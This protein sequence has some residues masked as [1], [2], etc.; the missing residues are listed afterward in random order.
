MT[1]GKTPQTFHTAVYSELSG[2]TNKHKVIKKTTKSK[3]RICLQI[4]QTCAATLLSL[5]PTQQRAQEWHMASPP[6]HHRLFTSRET[7]AFPELNYRETLVMEDVNIR[8]CP[9]T[10]QTYNH[11]AKTPYSLL[12]FEL[13]MFPFIAIC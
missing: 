8:T 12:Y 5:W 1:G 6:Q 9:S 13:K 3:C 7:E 11:V 4:C 10:S 2:D